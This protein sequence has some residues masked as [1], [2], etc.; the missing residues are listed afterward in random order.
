MLCVVCV[1]GFERS[2]LGEEGGN[3][4]GIGDRGHP[5]FCACHITCSPSSMY[6]HRRTSALLRNIRNIRIC[7]RKKPIVFV[8]YENERISIKNRL[9]NLKCVLRLSSGST[10]RFMAVFWIH[11]YVSSFLS[12]E[13]KPSTYKHVNRPVDHTGET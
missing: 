4:A 8:T 3:G 11:V 7:L 5:F 13:R 9:P 6:E 2:G 12:I 1:A 10:G